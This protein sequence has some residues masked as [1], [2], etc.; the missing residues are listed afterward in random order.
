M[1]LLRSRTGFRRLALVLATAQVLA[2]AM[3]PVLEAVT[4]RPQG[5]HSVEV[6]HNGS[7][8]PA[9][10]PTTCL[11]CQLLTLTAQ[12]GHSVSIPAADRHCVTFAFHLRSAAP[13][14]PPEGP[15]TR[16]PPRLA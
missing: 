4:E 10:Q 9:H 13:R 11:A 15:L 16:A 3:A 7:C 1:A 5:P 8:V 12:Q 6:A 14:A 2:Y